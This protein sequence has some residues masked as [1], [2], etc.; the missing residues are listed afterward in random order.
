MQ[1]RHTVPD[2]HRY[3]DP[4]GDAAP[5]FAACRL[6]VKEGEPA[7][8]PRSIACTYWGHQ[9]DCPLFEGAGGAARTEPRA[10]ERRA[11]RDVPVAMDAVWPVRAPGARDGMRLVLIGL[12]AA[13]DHPDAPDRGGRPRRSSREEE[14]C[15]LPA[16][17]VGGGDGIDRDPRPGHAP[18]V[19]PA[20]RGNADAGASALRSFQRTGNLIGTRWPVRVLGCLGWRRE[21]R[22][23]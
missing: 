13:L 12:G 23:A 5:I 18:D 21:R 14:P 11:S 17:R 16:P 2:W 9:R 22:L 1:C 7:R 10:A 8:D 3:V 20:M 6:L 4:A 15:R 19:G